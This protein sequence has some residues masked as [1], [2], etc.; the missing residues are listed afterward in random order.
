MAAAAVIKSDFLYLKKQKK[1]AIN[2]E[3]KMMCVFLGRKWNGELE[4]P[5]QEEII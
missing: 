4:K 1:S 2:G 3:H 5:K